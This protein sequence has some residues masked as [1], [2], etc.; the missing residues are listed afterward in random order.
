LMP[1]LRKSKKP[2]VANMSSMMG[3]IADNSSGGYY[4]YRI[5]KTALNMFTKTLSIEQRQWV[6]VSLHPGWVKT[7]MGG[8]EAPLSPQESGQKLFKLIMD[9]QLEQSGRFYD[10]SGRELPW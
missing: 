2:I 8:A 7:A 10:Y 4:S 9:L 3:S 6:V 5:S 1:L